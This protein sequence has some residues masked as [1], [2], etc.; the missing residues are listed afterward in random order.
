MNPLIGWGLAAVALAVGY[1]SYGW[2]GMLLGVSV[3]VFWLLLQFSR[4]LRVMRNAAGRPVGSIDN[5]VM[6]H[7]KLKP[8][9]RLLDILPLTRSLGQKVADDPETFVWTDGGGDRVR[10]ELRNGRCTAFALERAEAPAP[11]P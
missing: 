8:G 1:A 2:P 4:S 11:P 10:V 5:A 9:L 3:I 7:T 6:L